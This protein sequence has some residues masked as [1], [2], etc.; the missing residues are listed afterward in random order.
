MYHAIPEWEP[1]DLALFRI[2]DHE[3]TIL[4]CAVCLGHQLLM[5]LGE[6]RVEVSL[7]EVHA[8]LPPLSAAGLFVGPPEVVG[9]AYRI[10]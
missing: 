1:I 10:V 6:V 7:E 8:V 3:D 4:G 9:V 2:M 5:K